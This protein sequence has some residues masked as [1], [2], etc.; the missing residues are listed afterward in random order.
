M[1]SFVITTDLIITES[2]GNA[3]VKVFVSDDVLRDRLRAGMVLENA[4][5]LDVA[6]NQA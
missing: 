1:F 2:Q 6:G 5:L 3:L 4:N